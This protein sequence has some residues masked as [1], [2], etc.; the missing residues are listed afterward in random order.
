MD[1]DYYGASDDGDGR[2]HENSFDHDSLPADFNAN[3]PEESC[4]RKTREL[5]G[6]AIGRGLWGGQSHGVARTHARRRALLRSRRDDRLR[7]SH[8]FEARSEIDGGHVVTLL[9]HPTIAYNIAN[10]LE[11]I[12]TGLLS[13]ADRSVTRPKLMV[14][15]RR[16][17]RA[18]ASTSEAE[19]ARMKCMV[20]S[21]VVRAR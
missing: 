1:R 4:S 20:W 8:H 17:T 13:V 7:V 2:H 15:P 6:R 16:T 19:T 18:S 11:T 21:T 5:R 14:R 10:A 3:T 12:A 9:C